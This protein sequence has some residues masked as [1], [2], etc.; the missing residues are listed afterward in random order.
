[1]ASYKLCKC[2]SC[3]KRS[4]RNYIVTWRDKAGKQKST[5]AKTSAEAK[6]ILA[7][8]ERDLQLVEIIKI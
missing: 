7:D 6:Q 2:G 5:H 3:K 8:V 1:M 4:A